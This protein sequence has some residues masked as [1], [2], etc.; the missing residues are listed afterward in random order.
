MLDL[1]PALF[2]SSEDLRKPIDGHAPSHAPLPGFDE[3]DAA[4]PILL[5][6]QPANTLAHAVGPVTVLCK[7]CVLSDDSAMRLAMG[8]NLRVTPLRFNMFPNLASLFHFFS[9]G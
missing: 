2:K 7:K 4:Y 6:A 1:D 5:T 9:L 3:Y 8:P